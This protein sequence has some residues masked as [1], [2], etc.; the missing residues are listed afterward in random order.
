[1]TRLI[2]IPMSHYCEKA[3]W[4]LSHAGVP[5]IEEAHL[6]VF[7][8]RAVRQ[9]TAKGMVPILITDTD[10]IQDST[11]ILQYLDRRLPESRKLY[12]E[13][14]RADIVAMEDAF[15]EVL[16]VETRRWVYFHW[17]SQPMR[18]V[19]RTAAQGVPTWERALAPILFPLMLM[20]IRRHLAVSHDNVERGLQVITSVFDKVAA[21]LRDGR[22]FLVGDSLTAA[23]ITFA[24]MAAPVLLPPEYGIV[25]P[26]LDAAPEEA[27]S[28]I[29]RFR[30]HPAGQFA[31]GLFKTIRHPAPVAQRIRLD[32]A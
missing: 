18:E 19:L 14:H 15:D 23:D 31:L 11:A 5:Y 20:Y 4:G 29:Q 3:R 13:I 24:S 22:R 25:L 30:E 2:T 10:V 1:M 32:R 7:H 12:P 16:G 6:Q 8:Y 17:Q 21:T 28:D 26:T 27:R 9:Y